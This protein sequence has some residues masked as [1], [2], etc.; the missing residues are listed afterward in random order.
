MCAAATAH[1]LDVTGRLPLVHESLDVRTAMSPAQVVMWLLSAAAISALAVTTR[2]LLV[3]V[4]GALLVSA[5]PEL[6]GRGDPGAIA[7]PAAIL[8]ALVQVLLLLAV[9]GLALVLERRLGI[10]RPQPLNRPAHTAPQGALLPVVHL[11]VDG[12]AA[13]RAP[14]GCVQ[15]TT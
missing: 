8:G 10:F 14:P 9:V 12:I 3:G 15:S 5:A 13:P 11:V 2:V 1:A 4:P 7:E 6:V